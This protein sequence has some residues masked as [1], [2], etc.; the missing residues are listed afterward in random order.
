[1]LLRASTSASSFSSSSD[2][3]LCLL[4]MICAGGLDAEDRAA[5]REPDPG[6]ERWLDADGAEYS[7]CSGGGCGG[8]GMSRVRA[9]WEDGNGGG[10][11]GLSEVDGI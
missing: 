11:G 4:P 1:M 5:P 7:A 3:A 8:I 9:A 2:P 10:V 6:A